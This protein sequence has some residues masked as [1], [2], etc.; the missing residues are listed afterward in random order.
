M[1]GV[2]TLAVLLLALLAGVA[3][4]YGALDR[5]APPAA[6]RR[7]IYALYGR[8]LAAPVTLGEVVLLWVLGLDGGRCAALAG[9][10]WPVSV[11]AGV[12]LPAAYYVRQVR[13]WHDHVRS[14]P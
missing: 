7:R 8:R 14:L 1:T 9:A 10:I 3:L 13:R 11:F 5:L 12:W 6:R 2:A 4:F